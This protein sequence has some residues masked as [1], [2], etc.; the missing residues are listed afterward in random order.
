MA[1]QLMLRLSVVTGE[2][3]YRGYAEKIFASYYP[4]MESQP[5]GFAHLLC[6]L[7]FYLNGASEI[8][9]VGDRADPAVED[10][11]ASAHAVYLPDKLVQVAAPEA[12]LAEIS[13]LLRDKTQVSEATAYV[14]RNFTCSRPVTNPRELHDMLSEAAAA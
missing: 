2:D 1:A 4:A 3:R 6:A 8:V 11:L 7:D 5:F 13:P 10:L 9:V 14:C 12:P